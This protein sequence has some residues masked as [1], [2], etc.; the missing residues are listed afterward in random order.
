MRAICRSAA[1]AQVHDEPGFCLAVNVVAA[2]QRVF[3]REARPEASEAFR[4]HERRQPDRGCEGEPPRRPDQRAR[5]TA[6]EG[7]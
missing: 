5:G 7:V 1:L 3:D 4:R 2:L 6:L